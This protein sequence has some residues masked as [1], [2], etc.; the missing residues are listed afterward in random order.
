MDGWF[1]FRL[2]WS[3]L[4]LMTLL[5]AMI[6]LIKA[7][8]I[9]SWKKSLKKE[10]KKLQRRSTEAT[11]PAKQ[12]VGI[13][14][15]RCK[16]IF[17]SFSPEVSELQDLPKFIKSIAAC[18]HPQSDQ[19]E[20]QMTISSLL[21]SLDKSLGRFDQILQRAGFKRLRGVNIRH[22]T[23]ARQWYLRLS[24]SH[25]YKWY[26]RHHNKIRRISQFRL[27]LF[28]DP[29]MWLAYLSNR[30]TLLLLIK[31]LM[32]DLYLYFG[33]LAA[34][35][36]ADQEDDRE[37]NGA[38]EDLEK[39]LEKLDSLEDKQNHQLD[40]AIQEI[41]NRL[42]GLTAILTSNPTLSDCKS[43]VYHAAM[44]ISIKYFPESDT[45]LPEA[46]LGPLLER[47]RNWIAKLS[48]G[49]DYLLIRRFY[50]VRLDTLYRAKNVSDL[51]LPKALK[52]IVEK[53]YATYGWVKWPLK[54]YRWA[55]KRSP[56][57]I[58]LNLGWFAAK[59]ASIA[60]ILGNTFDRTCEELEIVYHQSRVL[61]KNKSYTG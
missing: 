48:K 34:E 5:S 35:V 7:R 54:V 1:F 29:F 32:V 10:I 47:S 4:A 42:I 31:Y 21:N 44:I 58:A 12:A 24:A 20:L 15:N 18:Y 51:I 9:L 49:E 30:L 33:N 39:T 59:K 53:T 36:Y 52:I 50:Q 25:V 40:P 23:G 46:A 6:F 43:A 61:K 2:F 41:R 55:K 13:I 19:P 57:I 14:E 16:E 3:A 27:F 22:I 38:Q 56:W 17:S 60:Y 11:G 26:F 28:Y 37:I 8:G 45:P